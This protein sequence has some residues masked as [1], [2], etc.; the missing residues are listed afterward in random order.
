MAL[1]MIDSANGF[2][3]IAQLPVGK[4]EAVIVV[5]RGDEYDDTF[6]V[7][8]CHYSDRGLVCLWGYYTA[9][10]ADAM[11]DLVTRAAPSWWRAEEAA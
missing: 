3:V 1:R 8:R 9:S 5:D 4:D 10:R 11:A 2:Q 6:A 7:W